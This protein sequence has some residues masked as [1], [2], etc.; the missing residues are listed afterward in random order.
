[1][2]R[3]EYV[4]DVMGLTNVSERSWGASRAVTVGEAKQGCRAT[5]AKENG[6]SRGG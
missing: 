1:M 3:Y 4:R 5:R 6:P 2:S